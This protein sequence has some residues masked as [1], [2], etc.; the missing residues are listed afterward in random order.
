MLKIEIEM[1]KCLKLIREQKQTYFFFGINGMDVDTDYLI[2]KN[3][4]SR[5]EN[6][7]IY[8]L[9]QN[10]KEIIHREKILN[11]LLLKQIYRFLF[12][13]SPLIIIFKSLV[14]IIIKIYKF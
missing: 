14:K 11:N 4:L 13:Y 5:K 6:T 2:E 1:E 10:Y 8:Y 3:I 7:T 9:N 12:V